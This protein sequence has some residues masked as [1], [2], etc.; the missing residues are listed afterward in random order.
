MPKKGQ[1][2][3]ENRTAREEIASVIDWADRQ[4]FGDAPAIEALRHQPT[5]D[6]VRG[7]IQWADHQG[8]RNIAAALRDRASDF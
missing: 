3:P 5:P 7:A 4:G 8:F 2:N 6:T 1:K